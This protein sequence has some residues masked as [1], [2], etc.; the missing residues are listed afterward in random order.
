MRRL[1][2]IVLC[3]CGLA[4]AG[5]AAAAIPVAPGYREALY[6]GRADGYRISMELY[7]FLLLS[8]R[9]TGRLHCVEKDGR[10]HL[11]RFRIRLE[12][13]LLEVGRS[14]RFS[15]TD[16]PLRQGFSTFGVDQAL[17]GSV[18]PG[19][20]LP[21][22]FTGHYEYVR[23]RPRVTCRTGSFKGSAEVPFR[24]QRVAQM[25]PPPDWRGSRSLLRARRPAPGL[26]D[27]AQR[28]ASYLVRPD[29]EATIR[30]TTG[31]A[32]LPTEDVRQD[33]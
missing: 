8:V 21:G 24:V 7:G 9:V 19:D 5:D 14:G 12:D 10:T 3:I 1:A 27:P 26:S 13:G 30:Q 20:M 31:S 11:G 28:L 33:R 4:G 15:H 2:L 23:R 6:R 22:V 18:G 17:S 32:R 25:F 29:S 16:R